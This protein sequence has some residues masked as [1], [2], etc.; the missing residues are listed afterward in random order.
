MQY[1][2]LAPSLQKHGRLRI[3]GASFRGLGSTRTPKCFW[4]QFFPVI[5]TLIK[6]E[7]VL[8]LKE[9]YVTIG[10]VRQTMLFANIS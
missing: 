5:C 7:T 8:L 9:Q 6:R 1:N 4:L 2:V 3:S 10:L